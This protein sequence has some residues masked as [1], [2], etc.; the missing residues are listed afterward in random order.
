MG[1]IDT[2]MDSRALVFAT[3]A[4]CVGLAAAQD[5]ASSWLAYTQYTATDTITLM[6]VTWTVPEYPTDRLGGPAPGFWFGV[7]DTAN[8][9][10]IQ[11]I[12]AYGDGS[13]RYTIFNG[14]FNW[15]NNNWWSSKQGEVKPGDVVVGTVEYQKGSSPSYLMTISSPNTGFVVQSTRSVDA[16]IS[17]VSILIEVNGQPVSP[18]WEAKT[19]V[20][21]CNCQG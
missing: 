9:V 12:L 17:F 3:V 1:P 20:D 19:E 2:M 5:P 4:L 11:P 14:E 16:D 7:E 15:N 18:T 10:L 8:M 6:N 13:P 21:A